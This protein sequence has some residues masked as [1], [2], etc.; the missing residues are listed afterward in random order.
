[1]RSALTCVSL[2][3]IFSVTV[4]AQSGVK[5]ADPTPNATPAVETVDPRGPIPEPKAKYEFVGPKTVVDFMYEL[6]AAGSRG[7]RLDKI[8]ALPT[9][10]AD[11]AGEQTQMT[12][13]AA[14]VKFDGKRRYDYNFFAAEGEPDPHKKL[15]SLAQNGWYFAGVV[16]IYGGSLKSD[17]LFANSVYSFPTNGN[18]Y[19][20]ERV[21]GSDSVPNQYLLLKAGATLGRNPEAKLQTLFE[22]AAKEGYRPI[23]TYYT[24]IAK[25]LFS[26]DSA[27]CL[28]LEK[29]AAADK[30][31]RKVV[32]SARNDGLRKE[33]LK[34]TPQGYAIESINFNSAILVRHPEKS[35]PVVYH[36]VDAAEK[37]Y[38]ASLGPVTAKKPV[39]RMSAVGQVGSGAYLKNSLVFEDSSS[40]ETDPYEFQTVMISRVIPKAFRKTAREY[41]DKF[42]KPEIAFRRLLDEGYTPADIFYSDIEGLTVLFEKKLAE[43]RA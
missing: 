6:K 38:P 11:S 18:I 5:P 8:T 21:V 13:L 1:M 17:G 3:L 10:S 35:Y 9:G 29:S 14:T 15:N 31:E 43:A 12:V 28:L 19:V 40:A 27:F 22:E 37:T 32:V 36:W 42:E 16:S 4:F 20:L 30:L 39:F 7:F 33:I 26:I 25:S 23:A 2:L 34:L 41:L 24:F